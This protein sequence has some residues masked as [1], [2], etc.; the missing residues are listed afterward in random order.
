MR[1]IAGNGSSDF[2]MGK[3]K[4]SSLRGGVTAPAL[5]FM[6][7]RCVAN[8]MPYSKP[9]TV[10]EVRDLGVFTHTEVGIT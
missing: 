6:L 4:T 10:A 7:I 3:R 2:L 8:S 5:Q 9:K 1:Y